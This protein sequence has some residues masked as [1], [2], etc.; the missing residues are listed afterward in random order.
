[1]RTTAGTKREAA[2]LHARKMKFG[3]NPERTNQAKSRARRWPFLKVPRYS[4]P[5]RAGAMVRLETGQGAS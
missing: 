2:R 1:M 3:A 4:M 5:D